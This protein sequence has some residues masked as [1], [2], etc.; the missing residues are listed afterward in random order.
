MDFKFKFSIQNNRVSWVYG[1]KIVPTT[2]VLQ[3]GTQMRFVG[4]K[5][6]Q[7]NL[8]KNE[9]KPHPVFGFTQMRIIYVQERDRKIVMVA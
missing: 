1:E 8:K 2:S 4:R 9:K 7:R 3:L 6:E 5:K